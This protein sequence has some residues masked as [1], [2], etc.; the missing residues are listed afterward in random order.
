[1]LLLFGHS[2]GDEHPGSHPSWDPVGTQDRSHIGYY[3]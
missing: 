1:M 3:K 2:N